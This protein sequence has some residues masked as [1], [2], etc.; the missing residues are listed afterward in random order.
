MGKSLG[1]APGA[2][3]DDTASDIQALDVVAIPE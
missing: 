3:R 1:P 2:A